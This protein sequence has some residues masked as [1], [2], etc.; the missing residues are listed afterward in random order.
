[1]HLQQ[2]M[3][4]ALAPAG[5]LDLSVRMST[6]SNQANGGCEAQFVVGDPTPL[7]TATA[8]PHTAFTDAPASS[9]FA[10]PNSESVRAFEPRETFGHDAF[11]LND[12]H[13][14]LV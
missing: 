7:A 5:E 2:G 11:A 10:P 3:R 1:M 13:A 8:S 12:L 14:A 4:P 9:V 6:T